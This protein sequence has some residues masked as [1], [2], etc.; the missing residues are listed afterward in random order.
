ML[1]FQFIVRSVATP[2]LIKLCTEE[3]K[4]KESQHEREKGTLLQDKADGFDIFADPDEAVLLAER[5]A[6]DWRMVPPLIKVIWVVVKIMVP[7]WI[8]IIIWHLIFRVPKK[9]P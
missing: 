2:K 6:K 4:S 1:N 7:F 5:A 9:G 8:P 3:H